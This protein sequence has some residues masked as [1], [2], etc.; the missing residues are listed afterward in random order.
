ML[1]A[2]GLP[3]LAFFVRSKRHLL[4]GRKA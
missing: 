3:G 1:L 4:M 2:T